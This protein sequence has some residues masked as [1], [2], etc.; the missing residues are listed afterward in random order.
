[1]QV[2][3]ALVRACA[4]VPLMVLTFIVRSTEKVRVLPLALWM[5]PE[6]RPRTRRWPLCLLKWSGV[7]LP[8][9]L[10]P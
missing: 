10:R 7:K 6:T 4:G 3:R 2:A 8:V 1:M 5:T 9:T